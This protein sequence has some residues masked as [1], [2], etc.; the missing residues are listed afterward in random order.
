M[1]R[2]LFVSILFA[3]ALTACGKKEQSASA[4]AATTPA[5]ATSPADAPK[6]AEA[7]PAPEAPASKS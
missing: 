2:T 7:A 4:P 6:P 3:I 5:P 1:I